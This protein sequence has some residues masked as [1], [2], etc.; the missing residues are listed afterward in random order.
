[1]ACT[2]HRPRRLAAAVPRSRLP[3]LLAGVLLVATSCYNKSDYSPTSP[4]GAG[5]LT[6]TTLDG[7]LSIAADGQSRLT[8]VATISADADQD[9]RTVSFTTSSGTFVGATANSGTTINAAAGSDGRALVQL[10]SSQRVETAI[11]SAT[12]INAAN[13][14]ARLQISFTA[15]SPDSIMRFAAA[16][17]S[18]PADGQTVSSFTVAVSPTVATGSVAFSSTVGTF[19]PATAPIGVDHTATAGLPSPP[20]AGIATVT[21]TLTPGSGG[22]GFSRQ[23]QIR[24]TSALP[25]VITLSV[26]NLVVM[27]GGKV[28]VIAHMTRAVGVVTPNTVAV[29]RAQDVNKNPVGDFQN[30]TVVQPG[31][32]S[33]E[34]VASADFL[35]GS[36][37]GPGPVTLTVGTNPPSVV[38]SA[39]ITVKTSS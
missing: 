16:P 27:P 6:L 17:A 25:E 20:A 28:H 24:F 38:G 29:F 1:M 4:R 34:S 11:V 9:K 23:T 39:T 8:L 19:S 18:A 15:P 7:T 3:L 30:V 26:D 21:A 12:I 2:R 14:A 33:L 37:I 32:S 31:A 5:A 36:S 13:V 22:S 10:Q 35:P